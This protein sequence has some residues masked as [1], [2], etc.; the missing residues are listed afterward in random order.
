MGEAAR[1]LA[2]ERYAWPAIARRLEEI[3][4]SLVAGDVRVAA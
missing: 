3:Y 1:I 4:A 2:V